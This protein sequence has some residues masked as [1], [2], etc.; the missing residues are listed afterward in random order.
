[1]IEPGTNDYIAVRKRDLSPLSVS[2]L[3]DS[4]SVNRAL[5]MSVMEG[6]RGRGKHHTEA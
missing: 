4:L 5:I 2:E 1:L 6:W 3:I